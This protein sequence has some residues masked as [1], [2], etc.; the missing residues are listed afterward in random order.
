MTD[1]HTIAEDGGAYVVSRVSTIEVARF[2]FKRDALEYLDRRAAAA[3]PAPKPMTWADAFARIANSEPIKDVAEDI[4]VP[5]A[6]LRGK[7]AFSR[8]PLYRGNF[9]NGNGQIHA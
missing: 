1:K 8:S 6:V 9:D 2:A 7:Y 3:E 4:G 5:W